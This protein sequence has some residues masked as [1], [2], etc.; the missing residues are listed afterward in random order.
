MALPV[1]HLKRRIGSPRSRAIA[2][3]A[4]IQS[5]CAWSV[6]LPV[7]LGHHH[8]LALMDSGLRWA[9]LNLERHVRLPSSAIR[10]RS[11]GKQFPSLE[12]GYDVITDPQC[13][14]NDGQGG[15]Y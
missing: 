6:H 10:R 7:R 15:I 1:G 14:R 8:R 13:I 9:D 2:G 12:S 3:V 11:A 5:A 4:E